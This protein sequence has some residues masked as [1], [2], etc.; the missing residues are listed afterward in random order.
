MI[1]NRWTIPGLA[2]HS[3]IVGD[4]ESKE[5]VVIDPV[6]NVE[7]YVDFSKEHGLQI[8]HIVE[9]H[10]HADFV[11]GSKE[12]KAAL[13]GKPLIHCSGMGGN[14][15]VPSYA[16]QVVQE[17]DDIELGSLSLKIVHTPGHTPEHVMW[18]LYENGEVRTLFSGDFLFV[19]AV[20]R[21]D[22]LGKEE[23]DKLSHQLYHT[24]FEKLE[25]YPD[26][27]E[28]CP[29]HGA[30][31]LCGKSLGFNP[32]S[33]LG[34]ERLHNPSLQKRPEQEWVDALMNEMPPIPKYFPRM[35]KI[36]VVGADLVGHCKPG[37]EA[38]ST[39]AVKEWMEKGALVLDVR[40]KEAFSEVHLPGSVNIPYSHQISTWAGWLF[41]EKQP[42]VLLLDEEKQLDHVIDALLCVGFDQILGYL[43]GGITAWKEH[44]F[45]TVSMNVQTVD[46]L[47]KKMQLEPIP[48]VLDVRTEGEWKQGH[49]KGS[50]HIHGGLVAEHLHELPKDQPISVV[51]RSGFRASIV[52]SLLMRHGFSEVSNI[53]GGV[54]AWKERG[55]SLID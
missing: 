35:K 36:N 6:R 3:Y 4:E 41:N 12:L 32:S 27:T 18:V 34:V 17:G 28:V 5:C 48:Y 51:C 31:S 46:L 26:Q 15:W 33:M 47:H 2:I 49:I 52:S 53:F 22:L 44:G 10:V 14:D 9:T 37:R 23:M 13:N 45:P 24:V 39:P 43:D 50:H 11:S 55:F 42:I 20:G 25:P 7:E 21:P 54:R 8:T 16:D 19:G 40:S 30:G 38:F 1:F 29:A